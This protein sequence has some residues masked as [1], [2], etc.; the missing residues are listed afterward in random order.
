MTAVIL[1]SAVV[2]IKPNILEWLGLKQEVEG[3]PLYCI[4]EPYNNDG[5]EEVM[6]DLFIG[7]W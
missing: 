7:V 6:A 3:Y 2:L 5:H 1:F 4:A